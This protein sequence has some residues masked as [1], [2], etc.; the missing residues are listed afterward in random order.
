MR[1]SLNFSSVPLGDTLLSQESD[2]VKNILIATSWRSG[3][4]F[5]GELLAQYPGTFYFFEPLHYYA[6][7]V[8]PQSGVIREEEFLETLFRCQFGVSNHG[9]LEH[10]RNNPVLL[11]N[12]RLWDSCQ[13]FAEHERLEVCFSEEYLNTVCPRFPLRLIK[14]VRL[15]VQR[16]R[17]LLGKTISV[18][19]RR[20]SLLTI[21]LTIFIYPCLLL[22]NV[23][24]MKV[25]VLV[26]DPRAVFR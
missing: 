23:P 17:K 20:L 1:H 3:S 19:S 24:N 6:Q 18:Q 13:L 2:L 22:E 12:K 8:T 25:L 10:V 7:K 4:S 21:H 14:T 11:S 5:L 26:R 15:R 16:T 9:F